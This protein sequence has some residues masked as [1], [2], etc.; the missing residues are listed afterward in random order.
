MTP[1]E[2]QEIF[3]KFEISIHKM[4][5]DN[6]NLIKAK[7]VLGLEATTNNQAVAEC[8]EEMIELKEVWQAIAGPWESLEEIKAVGWVGASTRKIRKQLDDITAGELIFC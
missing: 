4:K 1:A 8:W 7:D 6:E 3:V 2:A 5:Q